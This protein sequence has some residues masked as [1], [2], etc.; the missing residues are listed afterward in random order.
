MGG[1]IFYDF[2][3]VAKW[4]GINLLRVNKFEISN[5]TDLMLCNLHIPRV[6]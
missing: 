3:A 5:F 2:F 6:I 4:I 1:C